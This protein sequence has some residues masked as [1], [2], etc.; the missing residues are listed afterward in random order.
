MKPLLR[1]SD[2]EPKTPPNSKTLP[3]H[4]WPIQGAALIFAGLLGAIVSAAFGF[5]PYSGFV[6]GSGLLLLYEVFHLKRAGY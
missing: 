1:M 6:E 3:G 4:Y 5:N 2:S